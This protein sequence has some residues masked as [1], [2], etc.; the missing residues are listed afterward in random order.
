MSRRA[1]KWHGFGVGPI[2]TLT[3]QVVADA[4]L[5]TAV[6]DSNVLAGDSHQT[7]WLSTL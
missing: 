2:V 1:L 7:R 3:P 4:K 5:V 6:V